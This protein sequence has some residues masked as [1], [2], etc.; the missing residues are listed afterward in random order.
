[1]GEIKEV[2]SVDLSDLQGKLRAADTQ[3]K[4]Q[5]QEADRAQKTADLKLKATMLRI[6]E[7]QEQINQLSEATEAGFHHVKRSIIRAGFAEVAGSIADE[8]GIPESAQP[9]VHFSKAAY[10]G[11]ELGGLPGAG[12]AVVM[13]GLKELLHEF[14]SEKE[15]HEKLRQDLLQ[16]K[17]EQER[18]NEAIQRES[19]AHQRSLDE[20]IEKAKLE[21]TEE[22]K[23]FLDESRL[24][25]VRSAW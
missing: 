19:E 11:F 22:F 9:L 24:S 12:I 21:A 10:Q 3:T 16:F 8:M 1:V 25:Y 18:R 13:E 15:K 7:A 6:K 4:Q 5:E 23:K 20:Q 17:Q 14:R 2:L